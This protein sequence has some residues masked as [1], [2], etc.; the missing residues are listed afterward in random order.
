VPRKFLAYT[1]LFLLFAQ[2]AYCAC[3]VGATVVQQID[4][5]L[6]QIKCATYTFDAESICITKVNDFEFFIN[7]N[8][9]DVLDITCY[10][11]KIMVEGHK[12]DAQ[13][14]LQN[15]ISKQNE[16]QHKNSI[17]KEIKQSCYCAL[18]EVSLPQ[19]TFLTE[20]SHVLAYLCEPIRTFKYKVIRP[21]QA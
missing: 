19:K 6:E 17:F 3:I 10:H 18:Y 13:T 5:K 20:N 15:A 7:G 4:W 14:S 12:D 16:Q 21:P 9:Y 1:L 11:N 8:L 2:N